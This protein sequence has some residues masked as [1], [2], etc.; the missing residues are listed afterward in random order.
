MS[1]AAQPSSVTG[2]ETLLIRGVEVPVQTTTLP[3]GDLRFFVDNP[4]VYSILRSDGVEPTQTDIERKLL[5]MDHVKAL[6]PSPVT[7]DSR[8]GFPDAGAM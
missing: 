7:G 1:A 3:H 2:E 6:I 5:E 4:R 8:R